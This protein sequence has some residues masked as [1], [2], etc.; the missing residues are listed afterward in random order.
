MPL[1]PSASPKV[2]NLT[3]KRIIAVATVAVIELMAGTEGVRH[4]SLDHVIASPT[5]GS[6]I[7]LAARQRVIAKAAIERVR[8]EPAINQV[9]AAAAIQKVG[10][11][12]AS[13]G[14]DDAERMDQVHRR[15]VENSFL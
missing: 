8:L 9:I 7:A 2:T 13:H 6:V 14:V 5:T 12:V 1:P 3:E 4:A 10:V 11:A 15:G